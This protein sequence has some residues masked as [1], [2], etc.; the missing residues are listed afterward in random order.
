MKKLL[1][2]NASTMGSQSVRL[3]W[4]C[5]AASTLSTIMREQ[6]S[7]VL[8]PYTSA[9][10]TVTIQ[11]SRSLGSICHLTKIYSP[12]RSENHWEWLDV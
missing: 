6:V 2:G 1:D 9:F 8:L 3:E 12:I 4:M 7:E 11:V 5:S 10:S